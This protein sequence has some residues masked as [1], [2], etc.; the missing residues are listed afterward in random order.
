MTTTI[1]SRVAAII[2]CQLDIP[3][4]EVTP[5]KSIT[6][7]LGGDSLDLVELIMH[8]ED[9]FDIDIPGEDEETL[10][11]VQQVIDYIE[12]RVGEKSA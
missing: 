12:R 9:E 5:D 6:P 2:S 10:T 4:S 8:V 11:T 3:E 7:D 1:A